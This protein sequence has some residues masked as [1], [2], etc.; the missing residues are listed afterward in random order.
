MRFV[1]TIGAGGLTL[2]SRTGPRSFLF[3]SAGLSVLLM[4]RR[5]L[6]HLSPL[7]LLAASVAALALWACSSTKHVP[8]GS[9]LLDKVTITVDDSTGVDR[10]NL[11]NY[12]RQTPNHKVLGFFKL[13]LATYSLSGRDSTRWYNRWL[14]HLGQPP[15]IYSDA[16]TEASRRQLRQAMINAGYM[17]AQVEVDTVARRDKKKMA[18]T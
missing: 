5:N 9:L 4:I 6:S 12:L 18:V 2:H 14:R 3:I 8:D 11:V 10:E 17:G 15:I 16:M 1:F 7:H 13:Q